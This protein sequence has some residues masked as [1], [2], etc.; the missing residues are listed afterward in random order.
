MVEQ[1]VFQVLQSADHLGMSY[2]PFP[3]IEAAIERDA[4][5]G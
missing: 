1:Q 2:D 3:E 4:A 5:V